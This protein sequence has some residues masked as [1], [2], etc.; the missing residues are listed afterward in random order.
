VSLSTGLGSSV[1]TYRES[2]G[3]DEPGHNYYSGDYDDSWDENWDGSASVTRSDPFDDAEWAEHWAYAVEE[4]QCK[5]P[6]AQWDYELHK[7]VCTC[8]SYLKKG[9][10]YHVYRFRPETIVKADERYL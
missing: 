10:C 3:A 7:W 9:N 5:R 6:S 1:A 4:N 8:S 2:F